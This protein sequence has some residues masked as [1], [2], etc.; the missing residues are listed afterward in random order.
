MDDFIPCFAKTGIICFSEYMNT[1]A[2]AIESCKMYQSLFGSSRPMKLARGMHSGENGKVRIIM[3]DGV[4]EGY[5]AKGANLI[6]DNIQSGSTLKEYKLEIIEE[7][8]TSSAGLYARA[9]AM[10]KTWLRDKIEELSRRLAQA[11]RGTVSLPAAKASSIMKG[12]RF[13]KNGLVPLIVQD[14]NNGIVLSLFYA[15]KE[16]L[17]MTEKS[18]FIWRYSRKERRLMQKGASSGNVQKVISIAKDCDSDAVLARVI[19]KGPAC[20]TGMRSCFGDE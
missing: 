5:I 1:A 3:S 2:A 9:G 20:H 6:M 10:E 12:I 16:A 11:V 15:N 17:E 13:D 14:A 18:G 4:T 8:R 19:P 7:I